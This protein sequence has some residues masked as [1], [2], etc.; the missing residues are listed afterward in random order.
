MALR[1]KKQVVFQPA[2]DS[3]FDQILDYDSAYLDLVR[4]KVLD[5]SLDVQFPV[6]KRLAADLKGC[7]VQYRVD[8]LKMI[9]DFY[10]QDLPRVK[11]KENYVSELAEVIQARLSFMFERCEQGMFDLLLGFAKKP[12]QLPADLAG[13]QIALNYLLAAGLIFPFQSDQGLAVYCPAGLVALVE[14]AYAELDRADLKK[15]TDLIQMGQNLVE[16]VGVM[17]VNYFY[18]YLGQ[19]LRNYEQ[20]RLQRNIS[21]PLEEKDTDKKY[22]QK[23]ADYFHTS[24][25]YSWTVDLIDTGMPGSEQLIC[26]RHVLDPDQLYFEQEFTDLPYPILSCRDLLQPDSANAAAVKEF[27][28]ELAAQNILSRPDLVGE[29]W[30]WF[31]AWQ[32][33]LARGNIGQA[34][35]AGLS[36]ADSRKSR[37]LSLMLDAFWDKC[38]P[39]DLR[40]H[41]IELEDE[42]DSA[43]PWGG[44][45]WELLGAMPSPPDPPAAPAV[46]VKVGRN[47]PC[48]CGSGKKYKRCC[49]AN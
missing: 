40:G 32:N 37:Q 14:K 26:H 15:R 12:V 44:P 30:V 42:K 17:E 31:V 20:G 25:L 3:L 11:R 34:V 45:A 5:T 49:G 46:S 39:W 33:N 10:R 28:R 2:K 4:E 43:L 38:R 7:L 13:R 41:K 35:L 1:V 21:L 9:Y 29:V 22:G 19:L 8:D 24:L 23:A 36:F 47:E 16:T 18:F 6:L 27:A 48:P